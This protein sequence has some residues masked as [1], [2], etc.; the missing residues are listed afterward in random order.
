MIFGGFLLY[1]NQFIHL[2]VGDTYK[3]SWAI[4]L[5]IMFSYTLPLIQSFANS[6]LESKS[7]FSFKAKTYISLIV[8]GTLIGAYMIKPFG[9]LGLI[10]GS[11]A[12]WILSQVIMNFY[13]FKI[14]KLQIKRFFKEVFYGL[15][16]SFIGVIGLGYVINFLP[17][18]GWLNLIIKIL[19][20]SFVFCIMIYKF[21]M[22]RSEKD[23][24]LS[25]IPKIKK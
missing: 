4:A 16:P 10:I 12:G 5:I 6:I 25:L 3:I 15:L 23:V 14:L 2:W 18:N 24:F 1:G 21:G 20:F 7:L 22:N 8:L 13:Y 19:A 17:G 11:T 9:V